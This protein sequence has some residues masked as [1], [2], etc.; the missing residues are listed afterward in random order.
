MT[1]AS[2]RS[3]AA[4]RIASGLVLSG[5]AVTGAQAAD[6]VLSTAQ[7]GNPASSAAASHSFA[8]NAPAISSGGSLAQAGLGLFAVI[9]LILGIAWVARR[10]GLV[11][12]GSGSAS[13]KVVNS[14]AL[15]TR[16]K[17]MTVEVGDTWLVL[18]VSPNEIRPLHTLPAQPDSGAPT[19]SPTN[20]P[21]QS[22]FGE[23]L[24]RAMQENLKK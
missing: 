2:R 19:G 18:G 7:A 11:R 20:P 14:L 8:G 1:A 12:H 9:A 13:I 6:V 17:V 16:Q 22:G 15:S 4:V 10:V 21:M 3:A 23:R 5:L 24:M